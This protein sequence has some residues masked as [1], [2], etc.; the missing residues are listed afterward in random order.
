MVKVVIGGGIKTFEKACESLEKGSAVVA[1]AGS[2]GAADF[3]AVS[4]NRRSKT[5]VL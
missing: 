5:L 3:I 2:G 1:F 4:Y